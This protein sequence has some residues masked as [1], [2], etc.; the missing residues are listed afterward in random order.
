MIRT[1]LPRSALLQPPQQAGCSCARQA[2]HLPA[3][4]HQLS[5]SSAPPPPSA[6]PLASSSSL[7]AQQPSTHALA[8]PDAAWHDPVFLKKYRDPARHDV[9]VPSR[10]ALETVARSGGSGARDV[11]SATVKGKSVEA[12]SGGGKN[13]RSR[14]NRL[15]MEALW[16]GGDFSPPIPLE[17]YRAQT[18]RPRHALLFPG[19]GSQYVGMH[20][21][22]RD[23]QPAR[24]VWDEAET[25]LAGFEQW[26]K[27]LGLHEL[28][29]EAG[30]LGRMLDE[31]EAE[32][33]KESGLKE[34]VFEGP[35]DELT[36]SSNAQPA[37]LITSISLLRTLERE[38]SLPIARTASLI[39]GHSSGEYSAAVATG[40]LSLCDGVRLTRLHGLLT[41]YALSLPSIGLSPDFDAPPSRRGQMSALVLNP[42]HSH[43][44]ISDVIR[45]VRAERS[46][47][48]GAEGTVEVASFNSTTQV[49]L[50][51]TREGIMKA[52]EELRELEIA[53]RA[54]D[55]PVSA[56]FHCSFMAPAASGMEHALS[57]PS[58]RLRTPSSPLVSGLDA[59]LITT[60]SSLV[61][62]LVAQISLPVRWSSCLAS[63]PAKHG[64]RRMVFLGPGQA[65]ANLARRDAK[66]LKEARAGADKE[67]EETEVVSVATEADMDRLRDMWEE[68]D[69]Q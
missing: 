64:V 58:I 10:R 56:P 6:S 26:R 41:H 50:A 62:N 5:T 30:V 57:S 3:A 68:E 48:E 44:E 40:A 42:G 33:R 7:Y 34:V 45:R 15:E 69:G 32:R 66:A 9:F 18:T 2:S 67:G 35:Q 27:S 25:A 19:S 38:Y 43:A 52:S 51:G 20:H 31:T 29:G 22:L 59:S 8:N 14:R 54:A 16:S 11:S 60:P 55:L 65:L 39:L 49:V 36:R 37:I 13:Q 47:R 53:S 4:S 63:L 17:S 24:D 28:E 46:G 21:Y 23:K 1:A 12:A 61:S